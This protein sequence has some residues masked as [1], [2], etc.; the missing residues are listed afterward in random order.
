VL[1][2]Q[3]TSFNSFSFFQKSSLKLWLGDDSIGNWILRIFPF[4]IAIDPIDQNNK[5]QN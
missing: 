4:A 1:P 3:L 5:M 2:P